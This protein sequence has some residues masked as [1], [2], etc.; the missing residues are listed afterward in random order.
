V[1]LFADAKP[2]T[3]EHHSLRVVQRYLVEPILEAH[4]LTVTSGYRSAAKQATLTDASG[5]PIPAAN[6]AKG[7]SQHTL[8][9]AVDFGGNDRILREAF[10]FAL[11]H[12]RPWQAIAYFK[13]LV[14]TSIHVSIPSSITTVEQKALLNLDGRYTP[15][16]GSFPEEIRA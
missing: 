4:G 5:A 9:E 14:C 12:L 16:T 11:E 2:G 7:T 10:V 15:W 8:G 3:P 6:K 13:G 1:V